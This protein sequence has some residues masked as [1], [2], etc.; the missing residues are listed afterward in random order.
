MADKL[1][2]GMICDAKICLR[3]RK[4]G[5]AKLTK[6]CIGEMRPKVMLC[7]AGYTDTSTGWVGG[8]LDTD[9]VKDDQTVSITFIL[10]N[11]TVNYTFATML[12]C[13]SQND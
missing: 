8:I 1:C 4:A 11:T 5:N 7:P 9:K 12:G 10:L 13:L 6:Q 3:Y 2:T